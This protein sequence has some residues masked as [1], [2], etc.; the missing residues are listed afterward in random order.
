MI[1]IGDADGVSLEHA[2]EMFRLLGG[3]VF[4]DYA[5]VPPSRLVIVPGATHVGL[6]MQTDQLL[7]I[8]NP[9]LDTPITEDP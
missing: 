2:V 1:L 9:F 8:I 5:G 3:G 6:M 7:A 4:G